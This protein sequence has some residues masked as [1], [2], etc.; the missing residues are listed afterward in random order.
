M[1]EIYPSLVWRAHSF[2]C[3]GCYGDIGS[4]ETEIAE[5]Q[6]FRACPIPLL[7]TP[8]HWQERIN[9][10]DSLRHHPTGLRTTHNQSWLGSPSVGTVGLLVILQCRVWEV[11]FAIM[12]VQFVWNQKEPQK[13]L[14][15]VNFVFHWVPY[16]LSISQALSLSLTSNPS[17]LPP[18]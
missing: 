5:L 11:H 8:G 1:R 2:S 14:W 12:L 9:R 4:S 16:M 17:S 6:Y 7:Y 10:L 15:T 3:Y 18:W 13:N